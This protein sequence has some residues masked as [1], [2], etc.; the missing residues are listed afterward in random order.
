MHGPAHGPPSPH[1]RNRSQGQQDAQ[2]SADVSVDSRTSRL[3]WGCWIFLGGGFVVL[4][5]VLG[6][7]ALV[8]H[9]ERHSAGPKE[10]T[11]TPE[12]KRVA[13]TSANDADAR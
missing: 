6:L 5:L 9:N 7:M 4:F 12:E 10:Q 8:L 3:I 1:D 2:S 13:T 11:E